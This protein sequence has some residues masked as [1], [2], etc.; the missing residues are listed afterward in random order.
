MIKYIVH[1]RYR[2]MRRN[3]TRDSVTGGLVLFFI[4]LKFLLTFVNIALYFSGNSKLNWQFQTGQSH[5]KNNLIYLMN[6][7]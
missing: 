2:T 3:Y 4:E 6:Y 5:Y 1:S 7:Y